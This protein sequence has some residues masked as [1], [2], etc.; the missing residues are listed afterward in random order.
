MSKEVI[1]LKLEFGAFEFGTRWTLYATMADS[2]MRHTHDLKGVAKVIIQ[3]L[4]HMIQ[5]E[6]AQIDFGRVKPV[7][8]GPDPYG[9]RYPRFIVEPKDQV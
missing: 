6:F 7:D 9:S 1:R 2:F 3:Q 8:P 5:A 4:S